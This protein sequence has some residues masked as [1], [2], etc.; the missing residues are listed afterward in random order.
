M[1]KKWRT[2]G[3]RHAFFLGKKVDKAVREHDMIA[4]GD[5]IL[6]GVSGGK[7]SMTLL[8]LLR[9]RRE[10][11]PEKYDLVAAHVRGDSRG[12][13]LQAQE[14]V[15]DSLAEWVAG[16]GIGL[17]VRDMML[18]GNEPLPMGCERCSRSR[19][20]TLFEIAGE[21]GC[22][23]VALGHNLEDFAHTALINLFLHG[24][25]ETMAFAADYFD[26]QFTLIRP[27]AYLRENDIS[28]FARACDF[29]VAP[30]DCPMAAVSRR[31]AAREL[32]RLVGREFRNAATNIVRACG[33]A[34]SGR[35][36]A[37]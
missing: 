2:A 18:S 19:R 24:R 3:E 21:L 26:G 35:E 17:V 16:E 25:L 28:R 8:R 27:L 4:D 15:Q 30:N 34:E 23:K 7:D 9:C 5:R 36:N 32:M 31:Q 13:P 1:G 20:R 11:S 37:V 6:V 33:L 14:D 10:Q 22:N 29:P 12:V